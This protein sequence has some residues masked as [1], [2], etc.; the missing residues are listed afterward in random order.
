[1]ADDDVGV[2]EKDKEGEQLT[3]IDHSP[4]ARHCAKHLTLTEGG[5]WNAMR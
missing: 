3:V 2:G 4:C 5:N 1:M